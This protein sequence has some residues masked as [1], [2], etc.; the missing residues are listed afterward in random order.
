MI[1]FYLSYIGNTGN[2]VKKRFVVPLV[3]VIVDLFVFVFRL[4]IRLKNGLTKQQSDRRANKGTGPTHA[5]K[6]TNRLGL[7][8]SCIFGTTLSFLVLEL[9]HGRG[10]SVV[11]NRESTRLVA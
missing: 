3:S 1:F 7:L 4:I 2:P 8:Q 5:D 6:P 10:A 11:Q 9:F